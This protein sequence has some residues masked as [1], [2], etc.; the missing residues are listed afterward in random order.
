MSFAE[1]MARERL[2]AEE[3]M[4]QQKI[5][6][7]NVLASSSLSDCQQAELLQSMAYEK[8]ML[9]LGGNGAVTLTAEGE[10]RKL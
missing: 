4:R 3:E 10:V 1:I 6:I 8:A 2:R 7:I 5:N 9:A